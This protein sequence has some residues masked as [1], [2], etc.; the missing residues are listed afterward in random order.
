MDTHEQIKNCENQLR[1]AMLDSDISEL[2]KLLSS[3]LIF[4]NHLGQIMSKQDDLQMH[5]SGILKINDITLSEQK[6]IPLKNAVVVSVKANI[7]GSFDNA[8]SDND[9]RFTR[10]WSK[11]DDDRWQVIVGHS[12]VIA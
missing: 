10:V 4:T 8:V 6:I 5:R 11:S 7:K 12:S 3:K 9:F 2:D 1:L